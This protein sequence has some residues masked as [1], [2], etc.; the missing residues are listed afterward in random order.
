MTDIEI[1]ELAGETAVAVEPPA[2]PSYDMKELLTRAVRKRRAVPI[3]GYV[4]LN[5]HFKTWTMIRDTLPSLA[6]GRRVLSTV[7]LLDPHTGN[8]HPLYTPFRSWS[9]LHDARDCDILL[10][11]VTGI[12]DSRD[13]GMPKHVRRLL[14]QM[15]RSN[16]L[17]RWTGIDWDNSD[18]RLRQ[19]TQAATKCRGRFANRKLQRLN[20]TEDALA[21]WAPNRLAV[22]TTFDAQTLKSSEDSGLLQEDPSKKR[23]AK[24]LLREF[25]WAPGSVAFRSYN[26]LDPVFAIDNNCIH[27]GNPIRQEFCKGHQL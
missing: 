16:V 21:M 22:L 18:R 17:V 19:L 24:V 14:P 9:Q 27:C 4:G 1:V 20:A 15:R 8:P 2:L 13:Q 23:Q 5:G 25:A 11:E 10:D 26:T 3:H 7:A 12:M 6:M